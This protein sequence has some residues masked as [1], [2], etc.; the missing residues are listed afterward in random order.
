[1]APQAGTMNKIMA[2]MCLRSA[3][4]KTDKDTPF[5]CTSDLFLLIQTGNTELSFVWVRRADCQCWK[6]SLGDG[7]IGVTVAPLGSNVLHDARVDL[8][9]NLYYIFTNTKIPHLF[10][11]YCCN[12]N[13][14]NLITTELT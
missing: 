10:R 7:N 1:M 4:T 13:E 5:L 14:L 11:T 12:D 8:R 2:I 6:R 3:H 9:N